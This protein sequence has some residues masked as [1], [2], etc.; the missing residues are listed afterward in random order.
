MIED[1]NGY[2]Q[3]SWIDTQTID[4]SKYKDE[5][6]EIQYRAI[7]KAQA[8]MDFDEGFILISMMRILYL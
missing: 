4:M 8:I 5:A 1:V 2:F 6:W 7:D 3:A